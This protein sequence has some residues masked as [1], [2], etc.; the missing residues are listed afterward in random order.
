M[1]EVFKTNIAEQDI[2]NII[3][4]QVL[5]FFPGVIINFDLEDCDHIL[6]IENNFI[7]TKAI[8]KLI[9]EMGYQ[10]EVLD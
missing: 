4:Q 6:R 10:C 3:V 2:A 1:V 9:V 8:Q 7:S 5:T